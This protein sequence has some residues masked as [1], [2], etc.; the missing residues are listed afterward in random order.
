MA[1][2]PKRQVL[3][4]DQI[5]AQ[6][7]HLRRV[8]RDKALVKLMFPFVEGQ[9]TVYNAQTALI[10][11]SGYLKAKLDKVT[12]ELKVSDLKI[13]FEKEEETEIKWA[14]INLLGLIEQEGARDM[15][16]LLERFGNSLAQFSANEYMKQPMSVITV[17]K[18]VA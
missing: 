8:E 6:Q 10:A 14:M 12:S 5:A 11:L 3:T 15:S 4:K 7:D 16:S 9:S 2:K 17:E 1:I 18:I 13:N